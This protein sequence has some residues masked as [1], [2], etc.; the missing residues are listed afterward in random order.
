[1]HLHI[2]KRK[3][4]RSRSPPRRKDCGDFGCRIHWSGRNS[5]VISKGAVAEKCYGPFPLIRLSQKSGLFQRSRW[6][7]RSHRE[8]HPNLSLAQCRPRGSLHLR[9]IPNHTGYKC[10]SWDSLQLTV[11]HDCLHGF[12]KIHNGGTGNQRYRITVHNSKAERAVIAVQSY[13]HCGEILIVQVE[14]QADFFHF[15]RKFVGKAVGG[16]IQK[17]GFNAGNIQAFRL[18]LCMGFF[19]SFG[20]FLSGRRSQRIF[21]VIP[22]PLLILVQFRNQGIPWSTWETFSSGISSTC[23]A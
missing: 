7:I 16:Q 8:A 21:T 18:N 15:G 20:S 1:M 12:H 5:C 11:Q 9:H 17:C 10:I 4:P 6:D 23:C 2:P 14:R 19:G 22:Y 13:F 3:N